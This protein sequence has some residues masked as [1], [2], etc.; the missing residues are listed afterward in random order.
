MA[1]KDHPIVVVCV[2]VAGGAAFLASVAT[3]SDSKNIHDIFVNKIGEP[4]P[5]PS[6]SAALPPETS[7]S[8]LYAYDD[9]KAPR[10][11]LQL[12]GMHTSIH[13]MGAIGGLLNLA[14][15]PAVYGSHP[16]PI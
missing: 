1:W 7:P 9:T 8:K 14:R 2:A 13:P 15:L 11:G 4:G 5:T 3:I 16:T 6:P 12:K 10:E